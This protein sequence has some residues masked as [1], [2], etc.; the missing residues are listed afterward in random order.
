MPSTGIVWSLVWAEA[1]RGRGQWGVIAT[2]C[3]TLIQ[4]PTPAIALHAH[5]LLQKIEL[6]RTK[7]LSLTTE[8][9]HSPKALTFYTQMGKLHNENKCQI[10]KFFT[11]MP[12]KLKDLFEKRRRKAEE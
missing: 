5:S 10:L 1:G 12:N 7:T 8:A 9:L 2:H 4:A 3:D 11:E 6:C